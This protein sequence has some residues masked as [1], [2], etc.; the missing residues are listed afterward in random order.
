MIKVE[1]T[2]KFQ[3]VKPAH[4]AHVYKQGRGGSLKVAVRDAMANLFS[5]DRLKGKRVATLLP[6]TIVVTLMEDASE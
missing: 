3:Q 2:A 1:V 5:D 4:R 6:V